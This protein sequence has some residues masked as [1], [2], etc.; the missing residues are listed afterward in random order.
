[1]NGYPRSFFL[2]FNPLINE[3]GNTSLL[4]ERSVVSPTMFL[5]AIKPRSNSLIPREW[6]DGEEG[7]VLSMAKP[8]LRHCIF[9]IDAPEHLPSSPLCPINPKHKS[10]GIDICHHHGRAINLKFDSVSTSDR[11]CTIRDLS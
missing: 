11:D 5:D 8:E 7:E 4:S 2:D 1:M 10:G 3:D 6:W 9:S